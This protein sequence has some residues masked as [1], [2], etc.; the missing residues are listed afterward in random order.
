MPGSS[1]ALRRLLNGEP[2]GEDTA[3]ALDLAKSALEVALSTENRKEI[4]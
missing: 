2:V 1:K 4:D 3:V